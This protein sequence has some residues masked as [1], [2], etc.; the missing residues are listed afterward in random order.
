MIRIDRT[1]VATPSLLVSEDNRAAKERRRAAAALKQHRDEGKPD[2]EWKFSYDVYSDAAVK[3][4]LAQLFHNKCAY[5]ETLYSASQPMDVEHW[6]PKGQIEN[7]DPD[8][9]PI[10]PGYWWLAADWDNL[11]PSCIDCNRRR[12]Q[13]DVVTNEV[14]NLGKLDQFPLLAGDHVRDE[15]DVAVERPALINPCID[16]PAA[17]FEFTP[18]G[19]I[20]PREGLSPIDEGRAAASIRVYAL[21][22]S[23]LVHNRRETLALAELSALIVHKVVQLRVD[24]PDMTDETRVVVDHMIASEFASLARRCRDDAPYALMLRQFVD[25]EL[26]AFRD[27]IEAAAETADEG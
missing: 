5:C 23:G 26:A 16:D 27:A 15:G 9:D 8:G 3:S 6:R 20:R 12:K 21:N 7:S 2:H 14:V 1:G 13:R 22:R 11:L 19:V 10:K 4:A 17:F 18:E 24:N 25:R